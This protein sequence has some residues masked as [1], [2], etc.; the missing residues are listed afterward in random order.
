MKAMKVDLTDGEGEGCRVRDAETRDKS[1]ARG[2][3]FDK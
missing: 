3:T 2:S 1:C